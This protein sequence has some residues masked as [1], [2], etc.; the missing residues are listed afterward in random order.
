MV[1]AADEI[2]PDGCECRL[3]ARTATIAFRSV[4][5]PGAGRQGRG[6]PSR[7]PRISIKNDRG[8]SVR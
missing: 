1:Q 8:T 3:V 6:S 5:Q 7:G 2:R 4:T